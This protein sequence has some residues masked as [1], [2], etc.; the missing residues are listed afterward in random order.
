MIVDSHTHIFPDKIAAKAL[1]KLSSVIRL[2]PYTQGTIDSILESMEKSGVDISIILPIVTDP[3]QFDSILR[4]AVQINETCAERKGPRLVSLAG[5]HPASETYK[6]QLRI[7]KQEGF[8]GIKLHPNYQGFLFD[9]IHYM[10][11]IEE[12]SALGLTIVTHTG[13]DPYTPDQVFCSPDMILH[14]LEEVAPPRFILAHMGSNENYAESEEKL[15]GQN[16]YFDTAYSIM[17]MDEGRLVRMIHR[18]G[19]DKVLF[20]TD[21]PW[22][23]QKDCVEKLNSL[24]GLSEKEKQQILYENAAFLFNL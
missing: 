16:V 7:I 24:S 3:H 10:R 2:E 13:D 21:S 18:H 11:V 22:T 20:G 14:V 1:S 5:I 15:C 8:A 23:S 17:H 12:G 9:D 4:F 6:E 19:A